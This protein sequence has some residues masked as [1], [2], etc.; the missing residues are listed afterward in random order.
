MDKDEYLTAARATHTRWR[1]GCYTGG[2]WEPAA[3][4]LAF[5]QTRFGHVHACLL[6]ARRLLMRGHINEIFLLGS[7]RWVGWCRMCELGREA[8]WAAQ[9]WSR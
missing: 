6:C 9:L 5:T 4:G 8:R 1:S 7:G 3:Y 2:C